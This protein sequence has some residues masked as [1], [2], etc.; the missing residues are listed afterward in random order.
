MGMG[1]KFRDWFFVWEAFFW[2][3]WQ[4]R[5]EVSLNQLLETAIMLLHTWRRDHCR[6]NCCSMVLLQQSVS[7]NNHLFTKLHQIYWVKL[8]LQKERKKEKLW[9][10]FLACKKE[11]RKIMCFE[12][13]LSE[14]FIGSHNPICHQ[15]HLEITIP[16]CLSKMVGITTPECTD[17]SKGNEMSSGAGM[18][19][20]DELVNV[21][22]LCYL[23]HIL[24]PDDRYVG[25]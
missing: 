1:H 4:L 3:G 12:W 9:P 18:E 25:V 5:N 22:P 10:H 20:F 11:A 7:P 6:C 14:G 2:L 8:V 24:W 17:E 16:E 23:S 15:K 21:L 13:F 19:V